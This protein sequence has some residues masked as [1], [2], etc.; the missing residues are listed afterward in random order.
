[1]K[2]CSQC[3]GIERQFDQETA[4]EELAD[5]HREGLTG[6]SRALVEDLIAAGVEG[7]TLLDIGGGVGAV[8][9]A[10]LAAGAASAVHVD[11]SSAYLK[12][13]QTEA[14][15]RGLA[16]RIR[17]WHGDFVDLAPEVAPADVVTLDRVICC[18][19]D[20][21]GLVRASAARAQ[22]LYGLVYPRDAWWTRLSSRLVNA[23][24]WL[25]R[26]PFRFFVHR[27][28]AVDDLVRA[29]GF[30]LLSHRHTWIWQVVVY[31]REPA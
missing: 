14:D 1:M 5:Y 26:T 4:S 3:A 10:L 15:R 7:A 24:Y 11:A 17:F 22:R 12:A 16:G 25:R 28:S 30:Q 20:M 29:H 13:A 2:C 6:T 9:H 21:P 19:H 8:Q 27:T 23:G 31:V 18:Y